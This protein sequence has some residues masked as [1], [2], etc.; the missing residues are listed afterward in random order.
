[1]TTG[2]TGSLLAH[3]RVEHYPID[4]TQALWRARGSALADESLSSS[5]LVIGMLVSA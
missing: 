5:S 2:L 1:M 3:L 4:E